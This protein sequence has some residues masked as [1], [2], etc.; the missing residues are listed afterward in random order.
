MLSTDQEHN[1]PALSQKSPYFF[2][3][4]MNFKKLDAGQQFPWL[5]RHVK[6]LSSMRMKALKAG[7]EKNHFEMEVNF[8]MKNINA[9]VQ[10]F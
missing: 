6:P 1:V 10:L 4:E 9:L 8:K 3:L 2:Y 7:A 5:E